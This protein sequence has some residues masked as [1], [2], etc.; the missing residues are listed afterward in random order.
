MEG[1]TFTQNQTELSKYQHKD[2]KD[3]EYIEILGRDKRKGKVMTKNIPWIIQSG[4]LQTRKGK[5]LWCRLQVPMLQ[6][7]MGRTIGK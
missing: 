3:S 1:Q 4:M 5:N 2:W 7:Y 6:R